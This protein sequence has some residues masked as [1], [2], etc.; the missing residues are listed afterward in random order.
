MNIKFFKPQNPVLQKYIDC[1]YF[2]TNKAGAKKLSYLGFP[3]H[4]IYVTTF[5][6]AKTKVNGSNLAIKENQNNK[7]TSLLI[8]DD[9]IPK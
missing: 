9:E 1:Y 6:N 4:N 8:V 5:A 7:V 2:L 3:S